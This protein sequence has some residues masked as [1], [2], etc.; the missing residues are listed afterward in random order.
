MRKKL[1][2]EDRWRQAWTEEDT[3]VSIVGDMDFI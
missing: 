2:K 3:M 1:T